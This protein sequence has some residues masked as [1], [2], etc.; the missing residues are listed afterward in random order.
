MILWGERQSPLSLVAGE[1]SFGARQVLLSQTEGDRLLEEHFTGGPVVAEDAAVLALLPLMRVRRSMPDLI[2]TA[3]PL[4]AALEPGLRREVV[5]ALGVLA[6]FKA[7]PWERPRVMEVLRKMAI[8]PNLFEDLEAEG[9]AQGRVEAQRDAVLDLF[10]ARFGSVPEAVR[11]A[12]AG[13]TDSA[14]LSAWHRA[15]A[16]AKDLAEAVRVVLGERAAH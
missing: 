14:R 9:R 10:D 15:V 1:V 4:V 2:T 7:E 16:R 3:E 12:V 13:Q 5:G 6:Y 11:A 8:T